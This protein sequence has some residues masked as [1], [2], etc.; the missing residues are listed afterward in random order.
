MV[1]N[2][3]TRGS[4]PAGLEAWVDGWTACGLALCCALSSAAQ[5]DPDSFLW[6]TVFALQMCPCVRL[7]VSPM[8]Q[9]QE[10]KMPAQLHCS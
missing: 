2:S 6:K 10:E 7:P 1:L 3:A 5:I 4:L 8:T 9:L